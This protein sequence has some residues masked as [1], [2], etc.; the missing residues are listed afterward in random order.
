M[1]KYG[2]EHF[3]II[4]IEECDNGFRLICLD[5]NGKEVCSQIIKKLHKRFYG[6]ASKQGQIDLF[7]EKKRTSEGKEKIFDCT[8]SISKWSE[9]M[10]DYLAS[11]MSYCDITDVNN[12]NPE[13]VETR[14]LSKTEQSAINK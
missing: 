4:K 7:G 8:T 3:S 12:F 14:L 5:N 13:N 1:R 9:N 11:A 10:S 6:M 2:I